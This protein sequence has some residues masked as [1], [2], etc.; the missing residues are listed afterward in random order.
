MK[1]KQFLTESDRK[2]ILADTEKAILESFANTFNKIK[3]ADENE[4][5][6]INDIF[7]DNSQIKTATLQ[8]DTNKYEY[9]IADINNSNVSRIAQI[10]KGIVI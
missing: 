5:N 8:S 3:R 7:V 9:N 6:D 1:K 4:I 2:Q 10:A